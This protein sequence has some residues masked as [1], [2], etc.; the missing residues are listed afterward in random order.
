M[1]VTSMHEDPWKGIVRADGA[2]TR[3]YSLTHGISEQLLPV[4]DKPLIYS[5][6]STLM[7]AGIRDILIITASRD[8]AVYCDLLG[9]GSH[10]G[11]KLS[12][13]VQHAL[14]GIAQAFVI[15]TDF[16]GSQ[17]VGLILGGNVFYGHGLVEIFRRATSRT[18]GATVFGHYVRDPQRYGVVSFGDGGYAHSIEE[19][20]SDPKFNYAVT[21][22]YLYDNQV[23]EIAKALSPSA[24]GELE[25]TDVN[26]AYL[27]RHDL[28]VEIPGRGIAGKLLHVTEGEI[29][30]VVVD[31]RHSSPTFGRWV[32]RQLS[33]RNRLMLGVPAGFAHGFYVLSGM[34][35]C[36]YK[37]TDY[38]APHLERM[39]AWNEAQ[40]G[41]RW[42]LL[43]SSPPLLS[44][45]DA[46]SSPLLGAEVFE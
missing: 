35:E 12:Y 9:D 8:H 29:F 15:G 32:A 28:H 22:F 6:L 20:P 30:D 33:D 4:Y 16:I 45:K 26:L 13:A 41:T 17:R 1:A 46:Q 37:C 38:Y 23:V 18:D 40:T 34:A 2:G 7:L 3:L 11:L 19:K 25:I 27:H 42:P 14:E 36:S 31:L 39:L 10:W 24:R 44:R 5:L 21:G 43:H